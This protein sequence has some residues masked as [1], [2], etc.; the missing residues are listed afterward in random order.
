MMRKKQIAMIF[1]KRLWGL[2]TKECRQ[3]LRN[4]HLLYLLLIPPTLQLSILAYALHPGVDHMKVGV[5]DY[6]QSSAA[7]DLVSAITSSGTFH[8]IKYGCA[9]KEMSYALSKGEIGA[10]LVIPPEFANQLDQNEKAPVQI[11]IDGVDAYSAG[12]ARSSLVQTVRNFKADRSNA[13]TNDEPADGIS[14]NSESAKVNVTIKD[15]DIEKILGAP[16]PKRSV[17]HTDVK[18]LYNPDLESSWYFIP[19][20]LSS[21]ITLIGILVS[22]AALLRERESG[23]LEQ[24]FVTP[25]SNGE[26]LVA[27]ILP[28][29][30][31]LFLDL[32]LAVALSMV[33]FKL[34][35][36]GDP[37]LFLAASALYIAVTVGF[38]MILSSV[39]TAQRQAQLA[40]YF[41]LI[42]TILLSGSLVPANTMPEFL[43]AIAAFNPLLYYTQILRGVFLKGADWSIYWHSVLI[44]AVFV[45]V[46]WLFCLSRFYQLRFGKILAKT[47]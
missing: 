22:S 39:C 27:K 14:A 38:G 7:R 6:S 19:G 1:R 37:S 13:E 31:L 28:L 12:I 8:P 10:G 32:F 42:P 3:I 35:F 29:F 34:P 24:L 30:L 47:A 41:I 23:T 18:V 21:V 9:E 17:L 26:I 33:V 25:Y 4:K 46:Q 20:I 36:R 44:L 5:V 16:L 45:S 43:Q 2:I 40:S 11:L 15:I